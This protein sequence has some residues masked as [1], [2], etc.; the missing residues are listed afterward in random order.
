MAKIGAD[1]KAYSVEKFRAL[2]GWEK[3][4]QNLGEEKQ[5]MEGKDLKNARQI[6]ENAFFY[7]QENFVVTD[8][9]FIDQNIIYNNVTP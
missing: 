3:N 4:F 9:I 8:D 6:R 1:C 7:L 2:S 5:Q